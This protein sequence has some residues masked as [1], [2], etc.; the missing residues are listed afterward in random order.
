M[1]NHSLPTIAVTYVQFIEQLDAR[2]DD[3]AIGFDP[4]LTTATNIPVGTIAWISANNKWQ[5]W[6]GTAWSDLSSSYNIS[7]SG[8]AST[9]TKLLNSRSI[10]GVGFDGSTDISITAN[11]SAAITFNSSGAG[12]ASGTAFNGGTA[13]TISYNS[14]GAPRSDGLGASGTWSINISGSAASAA[15]STYATS[16]GQANS[17]LFANTCNS[18]T[19]AVRLTTVNWTISEEAGGRLV[20]RY[21]DVVKFTLDMDGNLRVKGDVTAYSNTSV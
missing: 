19:D 14:I 3:I 8:N 9:A 12:A 17:A 16:S 6:S 20:F 18:A 7:I 5:K 21:A 10:N 4:A 13:R 15:S 11:T 2:M 1:A